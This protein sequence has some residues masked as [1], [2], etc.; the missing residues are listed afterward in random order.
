MIEIIGA[1]KILFGS[2]FP[3][4]VY[5][6]TQKVPDYSTFIDAIQNEAELNDE[7]RAAIMHGN[8]QRLLGK[9]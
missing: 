7:E 9:V 2:D 4:R 3:L 6:R 5:P 1:D 8:M